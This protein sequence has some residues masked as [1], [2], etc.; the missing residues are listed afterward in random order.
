MTPP[1]HRELIKAHIRQNH[2]SLEAFER[3]EKLPFHSV[4]DVLRGRAVR[5][6]AEAIAKEVGKSVSELWPGMYADSGDSS[7]KSDASTANPDAH[8]LSDEAA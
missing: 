7:D 3:T 8:R 5:R 6:T 2:G 1:L 4:S